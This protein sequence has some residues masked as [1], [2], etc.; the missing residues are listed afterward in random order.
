MFDQLVSNIRVQSTRRGYATF[1]YKFHH[2]LSANI[3]TNKWD[4]SIDKANQ[5][6]EYSAQENFISEI[7]IL[8]RQYRTDLLCQRLRWLKFRFYLFYF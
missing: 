5:Y 6:L 7:D 8:T 4:I 2:R 3:L 1:T